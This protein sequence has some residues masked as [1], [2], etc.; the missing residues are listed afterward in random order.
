MGVLKTVVF[1]FALAVILGAMF[2]LTYPRV[3][4]DV[5]LASLFALSGLAIVLSLRGAWRALR[6][7]HR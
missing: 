1:G 4:I 3:E 6:R 5:A 7:R 2:S